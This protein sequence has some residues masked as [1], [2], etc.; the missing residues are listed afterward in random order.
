MVEEQRTHPACSDSDRAATC[1]A[2]PSPRDIHRSSRVYCPPCRWTTQ[3]TSG[4]SASAP[5][6]VWSIGR[7]CF[8]G[9]SI[10]PLHH[11]A[12]TAARL[13]DRPGRG[14][15]E[16]PHSRRRQIAM[17]LL[18]NLLHGYA[19]EGSIF[20][21]VVGIRP[22]CR[23]SS[24]L[25]EAAV[26]RRTASACW[27]RAPWTEAPFRSLLLPSP[28]TSPLPER[29]RAAET[30]F[31][32]SIL[33]ASSLIV[34]KGTR[35]PESTS[36]QHPSFLSRILASIRYSY[37]LAGRPVFSFK[38]RLPFCGFLKSNMFVRTTCAAVER[39]L[40]TLT[41][42][43]VVLDEAKDGALVGHGVIDVVVLRIRRDHQQRK[44]WSVAA[45]ALC[46]QCGRDR[47]RAPWNHRRTIPVA[48]S[49]SAADR[50]LIHD[51]AHLVIVP[52]V[53]VVIR[54]DD[55]GVLPVRLLLQ[56]VDDVHVRRSAHPADR[57]SRRGR[58]DSQEPS[59]S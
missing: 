24:P 19:I 30:F 44:T 15:V 26:D 59:G 21:C 16:S 51:R 31:V 35:V 13:E 39:T 28:S 20:V 17:H 40:D 27:D 5:C 29:L 23:C 33:V 22:A 53:G 55:R 10:R 48:T 36:L 25:P 11:E 45:T 52:T 37:S 12:L 38:K 57:S 2:P 58:P 4:L 9:S 54:D 1:P 18:V 7:K 6:S 50:R 56:E 8:A 14:A 49:A 41:A 32:R 34:N 3:R 46:M 47:Q 42:N 43:P